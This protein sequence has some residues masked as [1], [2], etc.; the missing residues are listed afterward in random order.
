VPVDPKVMPVL[1]QMRLETLID[2]KQWAKPYQGHE[3]P[4]RAS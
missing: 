4:H 1:R 3:H 2:G